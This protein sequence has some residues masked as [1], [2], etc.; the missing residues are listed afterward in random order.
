MKK[1]IPNMVTL[2]NLFCGC[3]ALMFISFGEIKVA[4]LM[5]FAGAVFDFADGFV[6]RALK[7]DSELGKQLDSLADTVTFGVVPAFML[8][9]FMVIVQQ[10]DGWQQLRSLFS[11]TPIY[12]QASTWKAVPAFLVACFSA[13]RL[14]K[15]N[16]DDRQTTGFIGM[17]TPAMAIFVC[18][19]AWWMQSSIEST[20]STWLGGTEPVFGLGKQMYWILLAVVPLLSYLMISP[21]PMFALKFKNYG[22]KGNEIRYIFLLCAVALVATFQ[23]PGLSLAIVLYVLLSLGVH[24][25]GKKQQAGN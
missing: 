25:L 4:V 3:L 2:G 13:Y 18:G 23:I 12:E 8:L 11:D 22:W 15:F 21:L 5:V 10:E 20:G 16:I 19:L 1:H 7:V 6:A 24:L 14:G 9:H 17:P